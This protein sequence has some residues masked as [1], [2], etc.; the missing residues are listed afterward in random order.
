MKTSMT[1]RSNIA[2]T[3]KP[4]PL[5]LFLRAAKEIFINPTC[6]WICIAGSFRFFGGYAIG[7]YMPT[8]F[9]KVYPDSYLLYGTLNAFVVSF[10]GFASSMIGGFISDRFEH[11]NYMTKAYVCM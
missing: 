5:I 3:V 1:S 10:G 4:N 11:R 7:Y 6:R 9:G 2:S 8:F